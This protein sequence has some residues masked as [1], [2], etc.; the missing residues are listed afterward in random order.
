MNS[1]PWVSS[2]SLQSQAESGQTEARRNCKTLNVRFSVES[3]V[4][5]DS[6]HNRRLFISVFQNH[7]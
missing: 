7:S 6:L 4:Q 5:Q 3:V 2:Q 1:P